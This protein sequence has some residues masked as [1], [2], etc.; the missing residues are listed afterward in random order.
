MSITTSFSRGPSSLEYKDRNPKNKKTKTNKKA[1]NIK[2]ILI[3]N[4]NLYLY[5]LIFFIYSTLPKI[6]QALVPPKPNE[7]DKANFTSLFFAF[8]GTKSNPDAEA[9]GLI[10][11]KVDTILDKHH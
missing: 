8:R 1:K 3:N 5:I 11:F 9:L 10:K 6:K 7:L 2:N 4:L